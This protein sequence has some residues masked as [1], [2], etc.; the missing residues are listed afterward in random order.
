MSDMGKK[1]FDDKGY[2]V[3]DISKESVCVYESSLIISQR[4]YGGIQK[5]PKCPDVQHRI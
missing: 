4:M 3:F 5:C 1:G 2:S